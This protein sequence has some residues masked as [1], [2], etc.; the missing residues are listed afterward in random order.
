MVLFL[1]FMRQTFST[2]IGSDNTKS[3]AES[4]ITAQ[5]AGFVYEG[6]S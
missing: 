4:A 3:R 1:N 5:I 6:F 2:E